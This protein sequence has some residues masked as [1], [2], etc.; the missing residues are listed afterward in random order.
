MRNGKISRRPASISKQNTNL[1][2]GEKS[3]KLPVGPTPPIPGPTLF[4]VVST[5]V[6]VVPKSILSIEINNTDAIM[7]TR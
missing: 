4:I 3:A 7:I 5:D 2:N 1:E 6:N